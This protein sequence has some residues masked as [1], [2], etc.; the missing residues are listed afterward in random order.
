[1]SSL[2]FAIA[3]NV[4]YL[5]VLCYDYVE[6]D[7]S[8]KLKVSINV[9]IFYTNIPGLEQPCRFRREYCFAAQLWLVW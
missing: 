8:C 6:L 1:M 5:H 4:L 9:D 7:A 2:R 3:S